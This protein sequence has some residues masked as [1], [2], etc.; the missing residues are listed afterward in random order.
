MAE[1]TRKDLQEVVTESLEPFAKAVQN[2]FKRIDKRFDGVDK[3]FDGVEQ[4]LDGVE[5]RLDGVEQ[6]LGAVEQ[7]V[8]WMREN[9]SELFTKLDRL[10]ALFEKNEQEILMLS[11]QLKRLEERVNKL[12]SQQ[13]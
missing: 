3:R 5:Q 9:S 12:E 6:R 11:A 4:R 10:I 7:D 2:D 13:R 8:K 1:I